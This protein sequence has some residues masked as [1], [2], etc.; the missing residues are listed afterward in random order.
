[1]E[2]VTTGQRSDIR[3]WGAGCSTVGIF[4]VAGGVFAPGPAG[5][6]NVVI[7]AGIVVLFAGALLHIAAQALEA[8][9][10]AE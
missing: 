10:P 3:R 8:K 9:E 1:M 7:G 6:W 5:L 4:L 2:P